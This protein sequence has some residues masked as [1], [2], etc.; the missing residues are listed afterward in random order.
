MSWIIKETLTK[1]IQVIQLRTLII[2]ELKQKSITKEQENS[3][4]FEKKSNT[5]LNNTC[6]INKSQR[7]YFELYEN[8]NRT[9]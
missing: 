3:Q 8:E 7:K 4:T 2:M 6:V 5:L 1:I 9:Y